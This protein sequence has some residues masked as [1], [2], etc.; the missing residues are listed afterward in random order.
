MN[1]WWS[2]ISQ[3][4]RLRQGLILQLF[5]LVI[6]PLTLLL[7]VVTF[8]SYAVHQRDM[9]RLV[10]ERDARAVQAASASIEEHLNHRLS[11]VQ[12]LS[13]RAGPA[14]SE[15][16]SQ[17][18]ESSDYLLADFD[19]GLGYI[20]TTG[21]LLAYRGDSEVWEEIAEEVPSWPVVDNPSI[22]PGPPGSG[23]MLVSAA[24]PGGELL[25]VGAFPIDTLAAHSLAGV[26]GEGGQTGVLLM[27]SDGSVLYNRGF[28]AET[29]DLL[30]HPGVKEALAGESGTRYYDGNSSEHVA[31]Y[32]PVPT[33][34]WALVVE[35]PWEEVVN[36]SLS[37]SQVAPLVL[38]PVL[39]LTVVALWF[40]VRQVV[41]PLRN[42]ESRAE[43]L[44]WGDHNALETP[45]GGIQ[46]IQ[47][48]QAQLI[49][50][51]RKVQAA[52][53]S[54]HGYIG[55]ITAAQEEERRRL[56]RDLHDDTI[57]SLIALKQRVQLA[58]MGGNGQSGEM[59]QELE[60][61]TEQTIDNLRRVT[62]ALRPIYLEDLGLVTALEMLAR[63]SE[64]GSSL[65]VEFQRTGEERRLPAPVELSLYRIAQEAVSN[66]VRHSQ[67]A[68]ARISIH[69]TPATVLLEV[70]DNG[71]G[72]VVPKTPSAFAQEGH[73]GLLGLYE[74]AD[75]LGARLEIQSRLDAGTRLV[76]EYS[77]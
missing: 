29:A 30:D 50:M 67:A 66:V 35:E 9:R 56:A 32:A 14:E 17:I 44:A 77:G 54:L 53:R 20:S 13:L 41:Q 37:A 3:V 22:R 72:F 43:A 2:R 5:A 70:Q 71:K 64:R 38:A 45:V 18:L 15:N 69:F 28:A 25:A 52:Q 57:Q 74:R 26:F 75:L 11:A 40:G 62:R 1:G 31:A 12:S 6:L 36:P 27:D 8:W 63:D 49:D 39:V 23:L 65:H 16:T 76:V 34:G 46:E 7:L 60:Q 59:L 58:K 47:T 55:E 48:L 73:F 21:E 19:A 68:K 4:T 51:S 33:Y 61:M 10:G 24:A 42:L